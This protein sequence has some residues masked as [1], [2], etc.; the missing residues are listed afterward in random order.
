MSCGCGKE[1]AKVKVVLSGRELTEIIRMSTDADRGREEFVSPGQAKNP[2]STERLMRYWT[3]GPGAAK[4]GWGKAC[5]FC[6]CLRHLRKYVPAR[7]LKG[8]CANLHHRALGQWPGQEQRGRDRSS[9]CP[10]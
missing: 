3:S 10:C 1:P 5:D 2:V 6:S 7:M 4:I 9:G 8:L